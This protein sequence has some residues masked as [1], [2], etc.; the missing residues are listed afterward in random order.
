MLL[1]VHI[2]RLSY[3]L[4]YAGFLS[5]GR[6]VSRVMLLSYV[7]LV[8]CAMLVSGVRLVCCA[9]SGYCLV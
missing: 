3:L 8:S 6:I 5:A 2:E 7:R 1:S 9:M 4:L